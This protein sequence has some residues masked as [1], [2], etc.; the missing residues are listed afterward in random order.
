MSTRQAAEADLAGKAAQYRPDEL[1]RYAQ[2]LDQHR[3]H[4]HHR[5][6]PGLRPRQPTRRKRLDHPQKHPRPHRMATTTPPRP[7]PT[8]HQHLPPPRTIPP[9]PRRRRQTR[10][11][12]EPEPHGAHAPPGPPCS[13]K[14]QRPG[15]LTT[16]HQPFCKAAGVCPRRC[17]PSPLEQ[18]V[19]IARLL[20]A[21][22][23]RSRAKRCRHDSTASAHRCPRR[24]S[25][26]TWASAA[27]VAHGLPRWPARLVICV[28]SPSPARLSR[29]LGAS[30]SAGRRGGNIHR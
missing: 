22:T 20:M 26:N 1:A 30:G 13:H 19:G 14:P 3:A 15:A 28:G 6:H 10:L 5:P 2:R 21:W 8:P 27:P 18:S 11:T 16:T 17:G 25:M 7:R 23:A 29:L 24:E 4:R 9:Q 12:P